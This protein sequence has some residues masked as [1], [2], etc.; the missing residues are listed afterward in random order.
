MGRPEKLTGGS[1]SIRAFV[2]CNAVDIDERF[3]AAQIPLGMTR[4]GL[5]A[6][7]AW[8][9]VDHKNGAAEKKTKIADVVYLKQLRLPLCICGLQRGY[10]PF[11]SLTDLQLFKTMALQTPF[12]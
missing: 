5:F 7:H 12:S 4:V 9:S 3:L 8:P 1:G 2:L 6:A 10:K 11:V